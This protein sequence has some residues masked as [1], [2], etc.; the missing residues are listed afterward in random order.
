MLREVRLALYLGDILIMAVTP[1][2]ALDHTCL[3]TLPV[4]EFRL[5]STSREVIHHPGTK[6]GFFGNDYRFLNNG[7]DS[8][9]GKDQEDQNGKQRKSRTCKP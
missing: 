8:S 4:G 2:V 6:C 3:L 5:F 7:T 9:R 1:R